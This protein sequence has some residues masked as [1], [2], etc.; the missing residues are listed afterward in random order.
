ML[1]SSAKS[2]SLKGSA[3]SLYSVTKLAQKPAKN[4]TRLQIKIYK[5][6][7]CHQWYTWANLSDP[8]RLY[9]DP[10]PDQV[11]YTNTVPEPVRI[12]CRSR[13]RKN[14]GSGSYRYIREMQNPD[15]DTVPTWFLYSWVDSKNYLLTICIKIWF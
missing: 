5:H 7:N 3:S 1:L 13:S 12:Q 15:T 8:H 11:L 14:P 4:L 10:N 2:F 9:V 6:G